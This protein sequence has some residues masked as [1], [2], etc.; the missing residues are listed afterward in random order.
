M[1]YIP[2]LKT[3]ADLRIVDI[4]KRKL[5]KANCRNKEFTT[6]SNLGG[7]KNRTL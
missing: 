4:I 2:Y 5:F 7:P 1:F 3:F 6:H